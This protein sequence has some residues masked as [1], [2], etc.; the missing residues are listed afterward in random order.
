MRGGKVRPRCILLLG[1]DGEAGGLWRAS[2]NESELLQWVGLATPGVLALR[3]PAFA[4]VCDE[5]M[6]DPGPLTN[7]GQMGKKIPP[8]NYS[9]AESVTAAA[10]AAFPP[11]SNNHTVF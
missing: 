9:A 7:S 6:R 10:A 2:Q 3:F 5:V 11:L 1:A 8:L 4:H